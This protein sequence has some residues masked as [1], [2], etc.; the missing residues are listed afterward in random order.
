MGRVVI[1]IDAELAWGFHDFE[2]PP[3]RRV[4]RARRGWRRLVQCLDAYRIPATWSIVGHLFFEECDGHHADHP[5]AEDGWFDRDPGGSVEENGRWFGPDL[6]DLVEDA[7]VDHEIGCHSFSHVL[8][9]PSITEREVIEA[10]LEASVD[11]ARERGLSLE[12]FVFPR[13]VV[14]HRDLLAKYGFTCYRGV[15][16]SRWYD[17][18]WLYPAGKFASYAVGRT[19][20]PLASPTV[21]EHGL[22]NVPG[23]LCLFS[24]EGAARSLVEPIAGDPVL[25]KAKLGIDAAVEADDAVCHLWLHPNEIT[26]DRNVDRLRR[27]LEYLDERRRATDLQI[28]TMAEVARST[29]LSNDDQQGRPSR[30]VRQTEDGP[31]KFEPSD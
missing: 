7:H 2:T 21:D 22:V 10:E 6:I 15:E 28:V 13:N 4:R 18:P 31:A 25:R 5:A 30:K 23:S 24:F 26:T 9:D 1:S 19:G 3:Q 12:S 16:P 29:H 17:R 27:I 14:G 11:A 20:P 8:F